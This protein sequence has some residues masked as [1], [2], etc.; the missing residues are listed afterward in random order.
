MVTVKRKI[1]NETERYGG[2]AEI[3]VNE[4]PAMP[5][6]PVVDKPGD[7][8]REAQYKQA[9]RD[10]YTNLQPTTVQEP[11][12]TEAVATPPASDVMFKIHTTNPSAKQKE[13]KQKMDSKTKLI[14]GVYLAVILVLSALVIATGVSL[15]SAGSR[16]E[17]LQNEIAV[18]NAVLAEQ[19]DEIARLSDED[20]I[21][22]R[23]YENGMENA[24][25]NGN[26]EL[27]PMGDAPTY[28]GTTNWFDSFCDWLSGVF[29]G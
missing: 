26:I 12:A 27:L 19:I 15:S 4:A 22:G 28:E 18:R 21:R 5:V 9:E 6:T 3:E 11:Q 8:F 10:Y 16:V 24:Q 1:S 29:G 20:A 7:S 17:N 23:A 25:S 13:E 2:F 14:L